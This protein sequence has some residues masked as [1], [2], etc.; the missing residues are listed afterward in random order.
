MKTVLEL[1]R[2]LLA[3]MIRYMKHVEAK[4]DDPG[5]TQDDINRCDQSIDTYLASLATT[6]ED[7]RNDFIL[8]AVKAASLELNRLN[9]D[10][11]YRLIETDQREQLC[12]LIISA[13]NKTGLVSSEDDITLQWREW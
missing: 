11:N 6:P 8:A 4:N 10:C 5:Y 1:K 9:E 2:S 3:E 13:A 7:N 12:M